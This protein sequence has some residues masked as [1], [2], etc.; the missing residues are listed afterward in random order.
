MALVGGRLHEERGPARYVV[1]P[2]RAIAPL[3]LILGRPEGVGVGPVWRVA[4]VLLAVRVAIAAAMGQLPPLVAALGLLV[5]LL[6][7]IAQ[8]QRVL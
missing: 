8:L 5:V 1:V 2:L 4:A 6:R 3:L 7:P